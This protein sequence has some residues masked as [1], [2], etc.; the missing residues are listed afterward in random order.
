MH[1]AKLE[2]SWFDQAGYALYGYHKPNDSVLGK[3]Y[4]ISLGGLLSRSR[5]LKLYLH[6]SMNAFPGARV[7]NA[8]IFCQSDQSDR[9]VYWRPEY[10]AK[11][12][13]SPSGSSL[14]RN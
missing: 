10:P 6:L 2:K 9:I 4:L 11:H 13:L 12:P 5:G 14:F 1:G 3:Q 7:P 8:H